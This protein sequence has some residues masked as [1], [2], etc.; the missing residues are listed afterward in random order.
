[1][2]SNHCYCTAK[3]FR[4]NSRWKDNPKDG[5]EEVDV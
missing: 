5:A 2:L 3:F 1:M 4:T